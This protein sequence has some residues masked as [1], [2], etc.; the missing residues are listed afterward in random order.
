MRPKKNQSTDPIIMNYINAGDLIYRNGKLYFKNKIV[1]ISIKR[2]SCRIENHLYS[3]GRTIYQAAKG[4]IPKG[5]IIIHKNGDCSNFSLTNLKAASWHQRAMQDFNLKKRKYGEKHHYATLTAKQVRQIR[6][7]AK[8]GMRQKD[9]IKE[10]NLTV[11]TGTISKII[12]GERWAR[13][14]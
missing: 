8:K 1:S 2:N 9:I 12:T 11:R 6:R 13:V 3:L 14:V 7:L 10:L 4:P 5:Q